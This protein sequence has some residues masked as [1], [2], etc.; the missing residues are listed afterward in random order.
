[1]VAG[2]NKF[3]GLDMRFLLMVNR[4]KGGK[5]ISRRLLQ[6][7]TPKIGDIILLR[8]FTKNFRLRIEGV[9]KQVIK[10]RDDALDIV[11]AT[12]IGDI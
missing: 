11:T 8:G 6:G 2:A 5:P 12:P 10:D 9:S 1:M 4:A 7:K 3:L